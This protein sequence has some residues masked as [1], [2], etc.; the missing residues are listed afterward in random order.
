MPGYF[1]VLDIDPVAGRTLRASDL[2]SSEPV[3]VITADLATRLFGNA[4]PIGRR[5]SVEDGPTPAWR[6]IVGIVPTLVAPGR[7]AGSSAVAFAPLAQTSDVPFLLLASTNGDP[8]A[9]ASA[10]RSR[11]AATDPD[12]ALFSVKSLRALYYGQGWAIRVFGT[13]FTAFGAA[14]LVLAVAGLYG[15]MAFN[16]RQRAPEIGVRM[17]LGATRT[18]VV[19]M[20]L[21]GGMWRVAVGVTA[22]FVPAWWLGN[23]LGTLAFNLQPNDVVVYATAG[24]A[25]VAAGAAATLIPAMRAAAL[26][27]LMVLKR[28]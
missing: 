26:D 12:L 9:V 8:L 25:I 22:G 6:T 1:E 28:D 5:V 21:W 18:D 3:M 20:I 14:A 19:R 11:F 24:G 15:V 13:L 17:A 23:L 10:V 27:P 16:V 2:A 7:G 4:D